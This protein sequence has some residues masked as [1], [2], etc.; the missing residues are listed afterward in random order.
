LL[1]DESGD[2]GRGVVTHAPAWAATSGT[3]RKYQATAIANPMI[4]TPNAGRAKRI[5]LPQREHA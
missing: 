1:S 5:E 4:A 3:G 2:T